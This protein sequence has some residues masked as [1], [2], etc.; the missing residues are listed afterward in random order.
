M[1]LVSHCLPIVG[2]REAF[3]L[4]VALLALL[5]GGHLRSDMLIVG[6]LHFLGIRPLA[7]LVLGASCASLIDGVL[8]FGVHRATLTA[9]AS[10][11]QASSLPM[12]V[13]PAV[14][15]TARWTVRLHI[16]GQA[17]GGHSTVVW[18]LVIFLL[19]FGGTV[20]EGSLGSSIVLRILMRSC[21]AIAVIPV[22]Q[23]AHIVIIRIRI[24][25]LIAST[26]VL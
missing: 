19:F 2:V 25:A 5:T 18:V 14:A 17:T 3:C 21:V 15:A 9:V 24:S 4:P 7:P 20:I 12:R 13:V 26:V 16:L 22:S 10:L 11:I 1:L 8:T 6:F 23:T